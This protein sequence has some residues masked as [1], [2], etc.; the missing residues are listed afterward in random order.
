MAILIFDH[1]SSRVPVRTSN[2][3]LTHF[4]EI[5]GSDGLRKR[6]FTGEHRGDPDL[7][8]LDVDVW[9]NDGSCSIVDTFTLA[10]VKLRLFW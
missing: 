6:E 2:N 3:T 9:R 8:G 10:E 5:K 7:I 4:V 1:T